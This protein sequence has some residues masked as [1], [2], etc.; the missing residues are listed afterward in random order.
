MLPTIVWDFEDKVNEDGT[1][2]SAED[3]YGSVLRSEDHTSELQS[4]I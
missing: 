3:Y 1:V 2:T 4:R